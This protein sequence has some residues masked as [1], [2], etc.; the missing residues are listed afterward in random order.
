MTHKELWELVCEAHNGN[1]AF[2]NAA[3]LPKAIECA[4]LDLWL[5]QA[6]ESETSS[7]FRHQIKHLHETG[8]FDLEENE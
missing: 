3:G 2:M 5:D 7:I 4:A 6:P 8:V 1:D